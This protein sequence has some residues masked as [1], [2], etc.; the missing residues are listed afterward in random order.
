MRILYLAVASALVVMTPRPGVTQ[1]VAFTLSTAP[2]FV[3]T[4]GISEL[5]GQVSLTADVTCGT[6]ADAL[7]TSA[8]GT[9]QVL[10]VSV[11]IDPSRTVCETISAVTTCNAPG[12]YL[13]GSIS[14]TNTPAG[15]VVSFGV[16]GGVDFAAGDQ[17][18]I[19]GVHGRIYQSAANIPGTSIIATMTSSPS[20]IAGF[21]PTSEVVAR[22]FADQSAISIISGNGQS[23]TA[24]TTLAAPFVVEVTAPMGGPASGVAI[25]FSVISGGGTLSATNVVTGGDGRASTTLTLGPNLGMNSVLATAAGIP[26]SPLLFTASGVLNISLESG[27]NQMGLVGTALPN[28]L[29]VRITGKFAVPIPGIPVVF[30]VNSGGGSFVGPSS[31]TTDAQ[32]LASAMLTLGMAPGIAIVEASSPNIQGNSVL[33]MLTAFSSLPTTISLISG[34]QQI[35][36]VGQSLAPFVV[37]VTDS[38]DGPS[39][40]AGVSFAVTS[41][42]GSLSAAQVA[43]DASGQAASTLTLGPAPGVNTVTATAQGLI[44][45]PIVFTATAVPPGLIPSVSSGG[46]VN[47]ASFRLSSEPNG[48]VAPGAIVSIFGIDL[49]GEERVASGFPLSTTLGET[50]ATFNGIAAPLFYVSPMQLN[51]QLPFN[52]PAGE[53]TVTIHRGDRAS[54]PRAVA[55]ASASPGIFTVNR[56]GQ[57]PGAILDAQTYEPIEQTNPT[58]PG[59]YLAIYC[60]GLGPVQPPWSSGEPAPTPPPETV[61]QPQVSIAGIPAEVSFSGLAPG[62]VGL[63][64]VNVR[65]PVGIPPG[66]QNLQLVMDGIP[67]NVVTVAVQ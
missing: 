66:L 15:G 11:P 9:I 3:A 39:A 49:A 50:S 62:Y 32:G 29:V 19:S 6:A 48:A 51:A 17:V 41:G 57:G 64:Q 8:G 55:V 60:T 31:T 56:N 33:F 1:T 38:T 52:V 43:S 26:G 2:A 47:G 20:T 24:G 13:T 54:E 36:V 61:S 12:T 44:G 65:V 34:N 10:Y 22:S 42:G 30:A 59:G 28:P 45:S 18:T 58:Y 53:A 14:V 25:I 4:T 37:R 35:G 21:Q 46:V 40:G 5:L 16:K 63:Y 7:C 23:A 27:S 67:S